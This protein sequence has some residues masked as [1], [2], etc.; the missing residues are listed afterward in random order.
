MEYGWIDSHAHIASEGL[1]ESFDE[2]VS[3]AKSEGIDKICI[4]CGSLKEIEDALEKTKSD[5]DMFDLAIGIHPCDV[6]D[7]HE[8]DLEKMMAYLEHPQVVCVGEIGLDYYWDDS[9][10][11]EQKAVFKRQLEIANEFGKP[12]AIH[13]RNGEMNAME[14]VLQILESHPARASGIVHCYSDTVENAKRLF[15]LGFYIGVGGIL[16]FKNGQNVRD[17]LNIAP[18]DRILTETDSPYLAPVPKRGKRNEPA[19]VR[20]TGEKIGE[21]KDLTPQQ[22]KSQIHQNYKTLFKR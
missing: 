6:K 10:R 16:T 20:Y 3:N 9:N 11:E 8:G 12:V 4:I 14:D 5:T 13:V 17:V 1:V 7:A 18:I 15:E 2:L 19:F 21:L 22:V